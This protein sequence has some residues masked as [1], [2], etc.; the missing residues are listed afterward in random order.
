M[1]A[2]ILYSRLWST[3]MIVYL[4]MALSPLVL[5]IA[6]AH[7]ILKKANHDFKDRN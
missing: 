7:A 5:S 1:F 4:V 6:Q 2:Y 3:M